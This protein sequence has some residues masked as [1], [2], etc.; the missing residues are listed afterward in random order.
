VEIS[1]LDP[2]DDAA[3]QAWYDVYRAALT[4]GREH[5]SAYAFEEIRAVLRTP[6]PSRRHRP[7]QARV[8]DEVVGVASIWV[9]LLENRSTLQ[10][11]LAV[12]PDRWG[13]GI[14]SALLAAVERVAHEEGR[15]VLLGEA[16]YPY[17]APADGSGT[18]PVEF[19]R[20]RGFTFGLGDV[21]RVLD[22]PTPDEL[23]DRLVEHATERHRGYTFR[24]FSGAAPDELTTSLA[25]LR[26][27][28]ETE[29]PTG[30]IPRERGAV[31]LDALRADEEAL[32]QQGRTR[33]TTVALAPDG[34]LAG[35]TDLVVPE[36]DPSWIYQ[37]GTLVWSAHRGHRLGLALK[38]RNA[39]WV[40][41]RFP[42]RR[43]IRTWNAEV[44]DHMVAVNQA[45]G[46]RP[47][48]RLAE[49][50]KRLA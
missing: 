29:A 2:S 36:F 17:E 22:L 41:R 21:Q 43:A 48:E 45:M 49:L 50:Q 13:R 47:V 28:V 34:S 11:E 25:E 44:N 31:D 8:G 23:L 39:A 5:H 16:A 18:S 37:W 38:A 32:S 30:D 7:L 33:H 42:H 19:A 1:Q 10:V 35:Y 24:Q 26:G 14:G 27:A 3:L 6:T 12:R 20:R 15:T 4:E 40:Q 46:F 9:P